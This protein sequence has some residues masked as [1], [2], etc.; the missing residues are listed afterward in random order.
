MKKLTGSEMGRASTE[1]FKQIQKIP[2][3]I[4]LENI[5]SALNTGSVFRTCDAFPVEKI[6]LT[7]ITAQ[8][9]HKDILK[10]ALGATESVNWQYYSDIKD[11][12]AELKTQGYKIFAAEQTSQ[13]ISMPDFRPAPSELLAVIFG[14]EVDGVSNDTLSLC[15]GVIELPQY[16]TKHSLNIAVCAGI[17]IYDLFQKM[18]P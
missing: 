14:N 2:V 6:V 8:P 1:G 15:D 12:I 4:I 11:C 5:R 10:T 3:V 16:G 18:K 7:G 17:I 13:S 9:P